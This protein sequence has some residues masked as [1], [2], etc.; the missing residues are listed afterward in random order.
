MI[1]NEDLF[2]N[3]LFSDIITDSNKLAKSLEKLDKTADDLGK[4]VEDIDFNNINSKDA[5][6][7]IKTLTKVIEKLKKVEVDRI[8]RNTSAEKG[9]IK[10]NKVVEN[11][12]K[13]N[14]ALQKQYDKLTKSENANEKAIKS[15]SKA[16]VDNNKKLTNY[17]QSISSISSLVEQ[18]NVALA[19][20]QQQY[21]TLSKQLIE[22][23]LAK[24]EY[25]IALVDAKLAQSG[26]NITVI[27]ANAVEKENTA[28]TKELDARVK[29]L[30]N[31]KT[32]LE[33]ITS[34]NVK[35]TVENIKQYRL[36]DRQAKTLIDDNNKLKATYNALFASISKL[37]A[38]VKTMDS[39]G[40]SASKAGVGIGKLTGKMQ[41]LIQKQNTAKGV[42]SEL[43][44][45]VAELEGIASKGKFVFDVGPD[46][47]SSR[48]KLAEAERGLKALESQIEK[49][50]R[51]AA[52]LDLAKNIGTGLAVG[53]ALTVI[54][55]V[56]GLLSSGLNDARKNSIALEKI[57]EKIQVVLV[58]SFESFG[59][60][61][62]D[63]AKATG[64]LQDVVFKDG[65]EIT[66]EKEI[67]RFTK[68]NEALKERRKLL[69]ENTKLQE[70]LNTAT[71]GIAGAGTAS[72]VIA[73][74]TKL[75]ELDLSTSQRREL[76][77]IEQNFVL[78][79]PGNFIAARNNFLK[80][81]D[82]F[83]KGV[84]LQYTELA[85]EISTGESKLKGVDIK[86][87]T[88][89]TVAVDLFGF[90]PEETPKELLKL[91]L[92]VDGLTKSVAK[93]G[94]EYTSL[95]SKADDASLSI[96]KRL[97]FNTQAQNKQVELAAEEQKLLAAQIQLLE[98]SIQ[99]R[100][101]STSTGLKLFEEITATDGALAGGEISQQVADA[102]IAALIAQDNAVAESNSRQRELLQQRRELYSDDLQQTL[103]ILVDSADRQLTINE[104]IVSNE[105]ENILRRRAVFDTTEKI[106]TD[107]Y[108]A[109]I[110]AIQQFQ[111]NV[112]DAVTDTATFDALFLIT[113]S[114]KLN[115][116]IK[117]L[118]FGDELNS[119]IRQV[120][121]DR[122]QAVADLKVL[123]KELVEA[124][125]G[126]KFT[127]QDTL[128][129]EEYLNFLRK[130]NTELEKRIKII[131]GQA[132][133]PGKVIDLFDAEQFLGKTD[134]EVE[135]L[136]EEQLQLEIDQ[137]QERYDIALKAGLETTDLEAELIALRLK[138]QEDFLEKQRRMLEKEREKELKDTEEA[139]NKKLEAEEKAL[140]KRLE[141]TNAALAVLSALSE[142]YANDR[143]ERVDRELSNVQS[144]EQFL[145][146]LAER[147]S[148]NLEENLAFEQKKAAE[149]ELQREKLDKGRQ[150]RALA[151]S[152][153]E[154]Y[155][156]N[157]VAAQLEK[158]PNPG[159]TAL[160]KTALD[161]AV[162]QALVNSLPAFYEGV[163]DTGSGGGLDDKDGFLAVLHPHERVLT[164]E[165][166][167]KLTGL[168]NN[169]LVERVTNVGQI[170]KVEQKLDELIKV[171]KNKETYLGGDYN[172][173][174]KTF[175]ETVKTQGKLERK[176][177]Q[178]NGIF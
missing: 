127:R 117:A 34:K 156:A 63:I 57:L 100:T 130:Q 44:T 138:Q 168:S 13:K 64:L 27:E 1:T 137:A 66:D 26:F 8:K 163:E 40:A 11:L 124:E 49:V 21:L 128:A 62:T 134:E 30:I 25:T 115:D 114:E 133:G 61:I 108:N 176:H 55:S 24:V 97:Q 175:V 45:K 166:N 145:A 99:L 51:R 73:F 135:R 77:A 31:S 167:K 46:G 47:K 78:G 158:D 86:E 23:R 116:A 88:F 155:N 123:N 12:T 162:L 170:N 4:T 119:A 58:K 71:K 131:K 59:K 68:I 132:S 161:V 16:L 143:I 10:L 52:R 82:R 147:G 14:I 102:F 15:I 104:E 109:Q 56:V 141:I 169:E 7:S 65:V 95:S 54:S 111:K 80:D 120:I 106:V 122:Q 33:S 79:A 159:A 9:I 38:S 87:R 171:T 17:E 154:T 29:L 2:E 173:I 75:K 164:A 18:N 94:T 151:L 20:N 149:L 178:V 28:I 177:N 19:K 172:E 136:L 139:N 74:S 148:E 42:V 91:Q 89:G 5:E 174:K 35:T 146:A 85:K 103:D 37:S 110:K 39:F 22:A 113:D 93:L 41:D 69:E 72:D 121:L 101:K 48:K 129:Q 160:T 142:K 76:A 112:G 36:L 105:E 81:L 83:T 53:G 70:A 157:L 140:K 152:I 153:L 96:E 43:K 3:N 98:K 150:Q 84:Q 67:E 6:K 126:I 144:R 50:Q 165:Q 118:G 32:A 90:K 107:S 125:L 60:L 92:L